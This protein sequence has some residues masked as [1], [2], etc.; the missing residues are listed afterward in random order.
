[1][2]ISRTITSLIRSLCC[3]AAVALCC[4]GS[5]WAQQRELNVE[6]SDKLDA[7]L[8]L[9]ASGSMLLTDPKRLRNEGAKL[10]VQFLKPGDRLGIIAFG[11]DAKVIRELSDFDSSQDAKVTQDIERIENTGQYTDI[12]AGVRAAEE[13]LQKNV[14]E[15]ATRAI[16]LMSDGKME[17]RPG[18]GLAAVLTSDLLNKSLPDLKAR[19]VKIH[20]LSFSEQADKGLLAEVAVGTEGA[21]YFTPDAEK[22]HESFADLFLVVKKPQMVPLTSKGFK[23]DANIEEATFYVNGEDGAHVSL[24]SP[25]GK[26]IDSSTRMDGLKWFK[27]QKFDVITVLKPEVGDWKVSGLPT[28]SGFATLLTN[29]KL[30]TD[31]PSSMNVGNPT[32]L[33]ARLYEAEKPIVLPEMTQQ[34]RYAFQITPTDRISEPVLRETLHDDGTHGD[35]I[36]NDGIFSYLVDLPEPGEYRLQVVANAPTFERRQQLSFR[37][38]PRAVTLSVVSAGAVSA[39]PT[40]A[41]KGHGDEHG[42]HKAD[43]HGDGHHEDGHHGDAPDDGAKGHEASPAQGTGQDSFLVELSPELAGAKLEVK[44]I[45]ID[46]NRKR[47]VIPMTEAGDALTFSAR[48]VNLPHDGE[49]ELQASVTGEGKRKSKIREESN[50]ISYTKVP[51]GDEEVRI[52]VVEEKQ[53][54]EKPA[55]PLIPL[56]VL[57]LV[58]AGA[59]AAG[60]F[61]I[62]KAQSEV[63]FKIPEF[64]SLDDVTAA[65]AELEAAAVLTEIDLN[66]PRLSDANIAELA[67]VE[68]APAAEPVAAGEPAAEEASSPEAAESSPSDVASEETPAATEEEAVAGGGEEAAAPTEGEESTEKTGE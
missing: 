37:L 16:I 67:A 27:G 3:A 6:A 14:R 9:D 63:S 50:R 17:P 48:S 38:K 60:F 15:G 66:D 53:P 68:E 31:W 58:N 54:E 64:E 33:Q 56:L 65:I 42:G 10:F 13:M 7:V 32:L 44:L 57:T 49:Y 35:K 24:I 62:K 19:G 40:H 51:G 29:L 21:H 11:D 59:T 43:S 46:K 12:A 2:T 1:M 47:F 39:S 34:I 20:T 5:L 36:A 61:L 45:A 26:Q 55:S 30:V 25:S 4:T 52:V 18:V 28:S 41:D 23:I 22:I 8:L